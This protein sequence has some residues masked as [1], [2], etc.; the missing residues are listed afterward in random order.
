MVGRLFRLRWVR[1]L[2]LSSVLV[3]SIGLLASRVIRDSRVLRD[4]GRES[5]EVVPAA[6][7]ALAEEGLKVLFIGNSHTYANDLPGMLVGISRAAGDARPIEAR[8]VVKGG[9]SLENHW[10]SGVALKAIERERWDFVVLQESTAGAIWGVEPM[11]KAAVSFDAAAR[12]AGAK[13]VLYMTWKR[14]DAEFADIPLEAWMASYLAVGRE[15]NGLVAPV[16]VAWRS[17]LEAEP[18]LKLQ[19]ADGNHATPTGS[20]LA[21]CVLY[22]AITGRSPEGL[23]GKVSSPVK[24]GP[25]EVL[26]ELEPATALQLQKVAWETVQKT[27]SLP[28]WPMAS[29]T[30]EGWMHLGRVYVQLRSREQVGEAFKH[31]VAGGGKDAAAVQKILAEPFQDGP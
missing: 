16:G 23:L 5:W 11:K 2:F 10:S 13:T 3:V 22:A 8:R 6:D 14:T 18:G 7:E 28:P 1:L 21:A 24:N 30:V 27:S 31:Y 20:Y 19:A 4:F 25:E 12:K 9:S 29:P 15:V 26:V 17:A